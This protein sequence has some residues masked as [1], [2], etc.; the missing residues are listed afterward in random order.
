LTLSPPVLHW[1]L[2][3][4]KFL[5]YNKEYNMDV[6]GSHSQSNV[7]QI[8]SASTQATQLKSNNQEIASKQAQP[9]KDTVSISAAATQAL[10]AETTPPPT[11]STS[12]PSPSVAQSTG[13][14]DIAFGNTPAGLASTDALLGDSAPEDTPSINIAA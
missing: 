3:W 5:H 9:S 14:A 13:S 6:S 2:G 10:A 4:V 11:Q 12:E 1:N 7:S 8:S